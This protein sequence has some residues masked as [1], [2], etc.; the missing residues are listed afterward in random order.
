M[1]FGLL[2]GKTM[3][4]A[5]PAAPV[6]LDRITFL[7]IIPD[8]EDY[9]ALG[10]VLTR[11]NWIMRRGRNVRE[12][13]ACLKQWEMPVVICGSKLPDGSWQD[14]LHELKLVP[15]APHFILLSPHDLAVWAELL[16]LGGYDLL[17]EPLNPAEFFEVVSSAWRVWRDE[18]KAP[19][20]ASAVEMVA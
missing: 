7:A 5:E 9:L 6:R 8:D 3:K 2:K 11:S 20:P 18:V 12:A 4:R 15:H 1:A 16:N 13:L 17:E 19:T 14:V 10:E